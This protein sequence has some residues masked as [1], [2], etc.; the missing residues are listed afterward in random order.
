MN[1]HTASSYV[2]VVIE[3]LGAV[4]SIEAS[5]SSSVAVAVFDTALENLRLPLV[6]PFSL[7]TDLQQTPLGEGEEEEPPEELFP[8]IGT[9]EVASVVEKYFQWS[10]VVKRGELRVNVLVRHARLAIFL[11]AP[12]THRDNVQEGDARDEFPVRTLCIRQIDDLPGDPS[13]EVLWKWRQTTDVETAEEG[14]AFAFV[15]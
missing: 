4:Q 14:T 8:D 11:F 5:S 2:A 9:V 15:T 6:T 1:R 10:G 12:G 7:P 3:L 13:S